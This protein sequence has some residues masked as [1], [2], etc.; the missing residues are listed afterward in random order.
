M[1]RSLRLTAR[2]PMRSR[3]LLI[4]R[5]ATI[6]RTFGIE[7]FALTQHADGVLVY[8]DFHFIN[9]GFGEED[10]A[11]QTFVAFEQGPERA[12]DRGLYCAGLGDQIIHQHAL[13]DYLRRLFLVD[14]T[15]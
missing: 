9:A 1:A 2:S 13:K 4:L 11:G 14:A 3:S 10:F 8:Q 6:R 12:I 7:H 15:S 5:V